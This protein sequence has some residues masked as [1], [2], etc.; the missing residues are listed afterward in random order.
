MGETKTLNTSN[1]RKTY[2]SVC[3]MHATQAL[4]VY[5]RLKH[6]MKPFFLE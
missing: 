2:S 5:G 3:S 4:Y 6:I 1:V